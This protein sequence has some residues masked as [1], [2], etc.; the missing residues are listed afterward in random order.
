VQTDDL[1]KKVSILAVAWRMS[2]PR[3]RL[4]RGAFSCRRL[5]LSSSSF[6]KCSNFN[7]NWEYKRFI[8]KHL[9]VT[10]VEYGII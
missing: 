10:S 7:L 6:V 1:I 2:P 9:F 8:N 5:R 4:P 3:T